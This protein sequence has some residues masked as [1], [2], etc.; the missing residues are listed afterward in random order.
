MRNL[1]AAAVTVT[2]TAAV[3]TAV[4]L[5]PPIRARGG[6]LGDSFRNRPPKPGYGLDQC[7]LGVCPVEEPP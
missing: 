1:P 5:L 6:H 4:R 2:V 3:A 7:V